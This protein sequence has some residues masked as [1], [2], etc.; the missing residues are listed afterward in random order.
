[1][2]HHLTMSVRDRMISELKQYWAGHP[3]YESLAAN[4]QGKYSF[5]ERPQFGMVVKTTGASN[6]SLSPDNF[7]GTL[8]GYACLAK[9]M[10]KKGTSIEWLREDPSIKPEA[11]VYHIKVLKNTQEE[12]PNAF[13]FEIQR[14]VHQRET[15]LLFT[16]P[17]TIELNDT[18]VENSLRVIEYPSN[19]SLGSDEYQLQGSTITLAEATGKGLS[20]SV[21]YTSKDQFKLG[22]YSIKPGLAYDDVIPGVV[23][24]V[25]RWIEEGDEQIIVVVENQEVIA[26]EYGGRWD[27]N[28]DIDLIARDAHSQADIADRT[29]VWLWS[30][31][32]AKLANMGLAMTDVSFGGEGEEVYDDNGDDYF[33][34]ASMS[35]TLQTDW[36]IHF[37]LLSPILNF[38]LE[39]ITPVLVDEPLVGI[40][41]STELVQRLL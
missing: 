23:F 1:M 20:L 31:L 21:R 26:H 6:M 16:D 5:E 22:P 32:R 12:D 14:Y 10:G 28:V 36:F 11:G 8:K 19:R 30:T 27:V 3:R 34:T 25:G 24:G 33:Y 9:V 7:I 18:P 15:N 4:I 17:T 13:L 2:F 39:G 38:S 37:P 29:V 41:R 40:G 35:L